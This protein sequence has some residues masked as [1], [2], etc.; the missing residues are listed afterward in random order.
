MVD[1]WLVLET[2][3]VQP[4]MDLSPWERTL[5]VTPEYAAILTFAKIITMITKDV[6]KT[7][8]VITAK[9]TVP[10]G[11]ALPTLTAELSMVV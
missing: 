8:D 7:L 11:L 1:A 6:S 5:F 3:T 9:P 10:A 2:L 4:M